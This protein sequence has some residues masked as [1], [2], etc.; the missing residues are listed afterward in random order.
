ME[1]VGQRGGGNPIPVDIQDQDGRGFER[2]NLAIGSLK[3]S[4][5]R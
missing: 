5:T 4:W 1:H 2:P 3:G